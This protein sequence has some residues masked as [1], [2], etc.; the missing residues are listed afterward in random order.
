[1]QILSFT[2]TLIWTCKFAHNIIIYT[3]HNYFKRIAFYCPIWWH[4][5]SLSTLYLSNFHEHERWWGWETT[6]H[7][8][9][10]VIN[11]CKGPNTT[12][13]DSGGPTLLFFLHNRVIHKVNLCFT[14]YPLFSVV[15]TSKEMFLLNLGYWNAETQH[16]MHKVRE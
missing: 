1:M 15:S 7:Y 5:S 10:D 13:V 4:L 6:Q 14:P 11:T 16:L 8:M 9:W 12:W 3:M 2:L